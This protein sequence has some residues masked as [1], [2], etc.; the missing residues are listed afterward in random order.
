MGTITTYT[1]RDGSTSYT[2]R[3]RITKSGVKVHE[4]TE[5]FSRKAT[6]QAWIKR[7]ETELA[8]PGALEAL[9]RPDPTLAQVIE[10]YL[11]ETQK[12]G[13]TKRTT[14]KALA[15]TGL[16]AEKASDI[17]SS[18][19][20]DFAASR[21]RSGTSPATVKNDLVILSSVFSVAGPAW[22]YRLDRQAMIDA[23]AVCERLG[24]IARPKSR[25]RRPTHEELDAIMAHFVDAARRRPWAL[26]MFKIVPFALFSTR[27]Q[28][29]IVRLLWSDLDE[30][31]QRILVRDVKHPRRKEGNDK[32]AYLPDRAWSILKSMPRTDQRIFPYTGIAISAAFT[33]ACKWLGIKD[34]RFHDFRHEGVSNLFEMDW[35]IPRVAEVSLHDDW[36]SLRRYTHLEGRGDKYAGWKWLEVALR[37]I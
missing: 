32:W 19:L 9:T 8:A 33:R 24:Y 35:S 21:I 36:A 18:T 14:L 34:L 1:K 15:K 16:G 6:A 23:K 7:R 25:T 37:P 2:A 4:E 10:Q 30:A 29:E 13:R 12:I 11:A 26:P 22:G 28:D 5:T 17:R 27:R 20:T 3:V 31:K